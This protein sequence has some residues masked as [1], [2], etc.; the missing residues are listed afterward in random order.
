LHNLGQEGKKTAQVGPFIFRV[1]MTEFDSPYDFQRLW[2]LATCLLRLG[3]LRLAHMRRCGHSQRNLVLALR[4]MRD[5]Y[6]F[7]AHGLTIDE[8]S[9]P[10]SASLLLYWRCLT[11]FCLLGWRGAHWPASETVPRAERRPRACPRT[12]RLRR[13]PPAPR[14]RSQTEQRAVAV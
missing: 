3:W 2:V 5:M 10:C 9:H 13:L 11:C 8:V 14:S 12:S 7:V 1:I 6:V 4:F